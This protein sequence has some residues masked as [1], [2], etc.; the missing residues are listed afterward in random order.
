VAAALCSV[1]LPGVAAAGSK[2]DDDDDDEDGH[3]GRAVQ[4]GSIKPTLKAPGNKRLKLN[5]G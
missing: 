3:R 5:Y 1:F 2:Q 4:V